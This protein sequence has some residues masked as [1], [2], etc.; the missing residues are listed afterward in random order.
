MTST[1]L[2]PQGLKEGVEAHFEKRFELGNYQDQEVESAIGSSLKEKEEQGF[3]YIMIV[4]AIFAPFFLSQ[5]REVES[6]RQ[7]FVQEKG[8]KGNVEFYVIKRT[9]EVVVLMK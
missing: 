8:G 2:S 6:V 9:G 7:D 3:K 1:E 4:H 5:E